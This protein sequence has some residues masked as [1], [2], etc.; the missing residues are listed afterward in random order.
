MHTHP[1]AEA[2]A[3]L[4]PLVQCLSQEPG[5]RLFRVL[6][7]RK[8]ERVPAEEV[9]TRLALLDRS[10][11]FLLPLEAGKDRFSLLATMLARVLP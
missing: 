8:G 1:A 4:R 5:T 9:Q 11:L 2:E 3:R 7:L 10:S 6:L